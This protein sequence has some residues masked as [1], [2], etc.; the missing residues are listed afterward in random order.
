ME[1]SPEQLVTYILPWQ[2]ENKSTQKVGFQQNGNL[3]LILK[4]MTTFKI[5][6]SKG[7]FFFF[8]FF[9]WD[10]TQGLAHAGQVLYHRATSQPSKGFLV[11]STG[12]Y[13]QI[14]LRR[15]ASHCRAP[16]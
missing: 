4:N 3:F 15:E 9:F 2:V 5:Y 7:F 16:S 1:N 13:V 10:R 12:H 11:G 6:L 14:T 8:V